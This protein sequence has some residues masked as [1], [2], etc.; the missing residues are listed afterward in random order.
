MSILSTLK[1]ISLVKRNIKRLG[2]GVGSKKGKT[3]ARGHKG[4]GSRSGY[5]RRYG[6]EGGQFPLYRKVP[7]RGFTRGRFKKAH[8]AINLSMIEK[9]FND[10]EVV[11]YETLRKKRLCP[12]AL[13]GGI[14]VLGDGEL[15]KKVTIEVH[16]I[17]KT[18]EEKITKAGGTIMTIR[19]L[20]SKNRKGT[21]VRLI[22]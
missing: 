21:K 13:P 1:N 10:G 4:Y 14:K 7:C 11:S 6:D 2:R 8:Y 17:S 19:D 15:N 3:C 22:K 12:Q 5:K 9:I 20:I 16:A 18:A